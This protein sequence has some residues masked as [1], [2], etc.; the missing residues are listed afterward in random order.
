M[1][2]ATDYPVINWLNHLNKSVIMTKE[3]GIRA[4]L[5]GLFKNTGLLKIGLLFKGD[6][7]FSGFFYSV[8]RSLRISTVLAGGNCL[9]SKNNAAL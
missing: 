7:K 2:N 6:V 9:K 1:D 5:I 8:N 4:T 3:G